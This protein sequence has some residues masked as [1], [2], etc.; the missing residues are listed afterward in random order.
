MCSK[1]FVCYL[2]IALLLMGI[3][4]EEVEARRKILRGRKTITRRYYRGTAIP[5][6]AIILLTGIGMLLLGGG[7]YALLQKFVVNAA[8]TGESNHSYTPALQ[9]E[10]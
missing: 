10:S 4:L 3:F 7:L 6:W 2:S 8:D 1:K 5:A 9:L